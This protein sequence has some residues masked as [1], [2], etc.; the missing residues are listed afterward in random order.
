MSGGGKSLSAETLRGY[1]RTQLRT[2]QRGGARNA[3]APPT[4]SEQANVDRTS[5]LIQQTLK[6]AFPEQEIDVRA[7]VQHVWYGTQLM[8]KFEVTWTNGAPNASNPAQNSALA[9]RALCR[10]IDPYIQVNVPPPDSALQRTVD[11]FVPIYDNGYSRARVYRQLVLLV[12]VLVL[13]GMLYLPLHLLSP[14]T[15][16]LPSLFESHA[17]DGGDG[18]GDDVSDLMWNRQQQTDLL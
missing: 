2:R 9:A 13:I 3:D 11:V 10:A 1:R 15:F 16:P 5:Q 7:N 6:S 14:D 18:G 17:N 12:F 4:H 8:G